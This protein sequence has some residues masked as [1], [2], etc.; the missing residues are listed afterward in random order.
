VVAEATLEVLLGLPQEQPI[1]DLPVVRMTILPGHI[2]EAAAAVPVRS[3]E[4]AM[5]RLKQVEM[6]EQELQIHL[7]VLQ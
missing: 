7:L 2:P 5:Q 3:E 6:V 4:M 1:K